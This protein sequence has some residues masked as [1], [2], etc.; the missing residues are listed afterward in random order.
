MKFSGADRSS[1]SCSQVN[2]GLIFLSPAGAWPIICLLA[3]LHITA[4]RVIEVVDVSSCNGICQIAFLYPCLNI[5]VMITCSLVHKHDRA[6]AH[7]RGVD[8]NLGLPEYSP[9]FACIPN[10]LTRSEIQ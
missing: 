3:C 7:A 4:R 2:K 10:N 6:H 9:R 1:C 5:M 8:G